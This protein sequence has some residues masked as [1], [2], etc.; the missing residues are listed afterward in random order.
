MK[1]SSKDVVLVAV[2]AVVILVIALFGFPNTGSTGETVTTTISIQFFDAPAPIHPGNLTT[3]ALVGG[4]WHMTSASNGGST[5]WVFKNVTSKSSCY[6]Q[7][8]EAGRIAPFHIDSRNESLGIFVTAI[9][10]EFNQEG[11]GPGWQYYVNGVYANRACS[12][13]TIDNGDQV[14]WKYQT[15]QI[16]G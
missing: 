14:A 12:I 4:E 7:L 6:E 11:G 2:A 10:G 15:N 1:L 16:P 5:T 13:I 9:A 3:W 8:L